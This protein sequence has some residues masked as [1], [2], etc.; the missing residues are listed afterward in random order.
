MKVVQ[1][2]CNLIDITVLRSL[3]EFTEID[4]A[5][6]HVKNYQLH[7]DYFCEEMNVRLGLRELFLPKGC[8][9]PLKLRTIKFAFD[10]DKDEDD[11]HTLNDDKLLL[12]DALG[13]LFSYVKPQGGGLNITEER[14]LRQH[15]AEEG[16][17]NITEERLLRQ[18]IAEEG[19][20]NI[21]VAKAILY[22]PPGV[23][24][25]T[26]MK[27]LIGELEN[28][29]PNVSYSQS[30]GIDAPITVP[31]YR[32]IECREMIVDQWK[33]HT[34]AKIL[35]ICI[36]CLKSK[37][38]SIS[39]PISPSVSSK[40]LVASS[41]LPTSAANQ[42][43][44]SP[45]KHKDGLQ[46]QYEESDSSSVHVDQHES[47]RNHESLQED[48][49]SLVKDCIKSASFLELREQLKDIENV[50]LLQ[51]VDI[52]GQPE[53]HEIYPLLL[54]GPALYLLF[55]DLSRD[56]NELF[57]FTYRHENGSVS[58]EYKSQ[59]TTLQVLH[60][61]LSCIDSSGEK[62]TAAMLIGTYLDE[63]KNLEKAD[64]KAVRKLVQ[65]KVG[66][67]LKKSMEN[68]S[69]YQ[70][71][72]FITNGADLLFAVDNVSG[73]YKPE[74]ELLQATIKRAL[75]RMHRKVTEPL[76]TSWAIF[77]FLLRDFP[78]KNNGKMY[79]TLEEAKAIAAEVKIKDAEV[80][81]NYIHRQ[82]GSVLYYHDISDD[83]GIKYVFCDTN[84]ILKPVT[85][86]V[87]V[88]LGSNPDYAIIADRLRKTGLIKIDDFDKLCKSFQS[89]IPLGYIVKLLQKQMVIS[90]EIDS[91]YF[92]PSLV[93]VREN[94]T[95][96]SSSVHVAPLLL[97]FSRK[98]HSTI[99]YFPPG[100]FSALLVK[101]V[102][103]PKWSLRDVTD[104]EIAFWFGE[105]KQ[106]KT[107]VTLVAK[108]QCL[109]VGILNNSVEP[110]VCSEIR[111]D[112]KKSFG[113][114]KDIILQQY[115]NGV[116][117]KEAF[118]CKS[119]NA[120]AVVVENFE[121]LDCTCSKTLIPMN[122]KH[123]IWFSG[124]FY[125]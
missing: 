40:H 123:R 10:W 96:I 95:V 117:M 100:L 25:T 101:L 1:N 34:M 102:A 35:Q 59:L 39:T 84:A 111:E 41:F 124:N 12:S 115:L 22:G 112:I 99:G 2:E 29:E 120:V 60:Q 52:G 11:Q 13:R 47:T 82:F 109:E 3:V 53:F 74:I 46:A 118:H 62:K 107:V 91:Q 116:S 65:E 26:L 15:I 8:S 69:Y 45:D 36:S 75:K 56:I 98:S 16:E 103:T 42:H 5:K 6:Q 30:T 94:D 106:R 67:R 37:A 70:N 43:R 54:S 38:S 7:V 31:V 44:K 55:F 113:Q 76:P 110:C 93:Y 4:E 122:Q 83:K 71:N 19:E 58:Q 66:Q 63:F 17:L 14:L 28:L 108:S 51:L 20:L 73:T 79:C 85:H 89:S 104:G 97:T 21:T 68:T 77:Y 9:P 72:V 27:R 119:C 49:P 24:K 78:N 125:S 114:I 92:I 81:L 80:A 121:E 64:D 32:D 87:A 18:H 86:L 105:Q 33:H 90:N 88:C 23:G 57:T 61:I 48:L 50:T